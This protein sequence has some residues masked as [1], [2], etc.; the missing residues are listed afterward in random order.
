[1][2]RAEKRLFARSNGATVNFPRKN[3]RFSVELFTARQADMPGSRCFRLGILLAI[4]C[5]DNY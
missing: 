4:Y 3:S 2:C 5:P 1:M